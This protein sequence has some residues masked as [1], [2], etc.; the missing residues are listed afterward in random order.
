M[1]L[2]YISALSSHPQRGLLHQQMGTDTETH[3]HSQTYREIESK[4]DNSFKSITSELR[5]PTDE[6]S[7]ILE[8]LEGMEDIRSTRPSESTRQGT[9]VLTDIEAASKGTT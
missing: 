9:Y 7:E 2:Y 6:E 8:K 4:V 5:D 3:T 1:G